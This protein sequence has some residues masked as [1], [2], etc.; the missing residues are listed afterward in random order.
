MQTS[1]TFLGRVAGWC[2]DHR[3][4]AIGLWLVALVT[5]F[6]A[7]GTVGSRFSATSAVPGSGS[8]AGFEVLEEHFPQLGTGG[9]SGTIVFR[10]P[11]GVDDP[12]VRTA[13]AALFELVDAGFPDAAGVPQHSGGT[14]V[15]PYAAADQIAGDGTVA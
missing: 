14:V 1:P 4:K 5:I 7:A 11:Q 6:G 10:A 3:A 13:M 12:E 8:A 2:F 15:S 9:Q